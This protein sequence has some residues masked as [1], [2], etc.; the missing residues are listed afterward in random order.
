M[1][2]DV[3][4]AYKG[5]EDIGAIISKSKACAGLFMWIKAVEI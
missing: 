4:K 2:V 1:E 3:C 5:P